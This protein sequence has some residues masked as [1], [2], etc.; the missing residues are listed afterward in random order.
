MGSGKIVDGAND[1]DLQVKMRESGSFAKP[2]YLASETGFSPTFSDIM[3]VPSFP[4]P[5]RGMQNFQY[6]NSP[7]STSSNNTT[8]NASLANNGNCSSSMSKQTNTE[9]RV[10]NPVT[11]DTMFNARMNRGTMF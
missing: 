6:S 8:Y 5:M 1:Y 9:Q 7:A 11:A 10:T 3:Q 2:P 4:G